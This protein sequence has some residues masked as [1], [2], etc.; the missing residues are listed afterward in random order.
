[1]TD[2][3]WL[4]IDTMPLSTV[5]TKV[6]VRE[7]DRAHTGVKVTG[8]RYEREVINE[9]PLLNDYPE[10]VIGRI[11][12]FTITHTTGTIRA[13]LKAEWRPHA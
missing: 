5:G 3:P 10:Q 9:S 13:T 12:D 6:D 1:M 8:I 11:D 2:N 4:P 7:D